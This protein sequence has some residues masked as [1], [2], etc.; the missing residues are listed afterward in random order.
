[1]SNV[2]EAT[3]CHT[4]EIDWLIDWLTDSGLFNAAFQ[5]DILC[6]AIAGNI[7]EQFKVIYRFKSVEVVSVSKHYI[8]NSYKETGEDPR[9]FNFGTVVS[10]MLRIL[11][12]NEE[13]SDTHCTGGCIRPTGYVV[14]MVKGNTVPLPD[15]EPHS[16]YIVLI[17]LFEYYDVCYNLQFAIRIRVDYILCETWEILFQ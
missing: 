11:Y 6:S 15:I 1:V 17:D 10:L 13:D 4:Y 12:P 8:T 9:T 7:I 5:L 14:M 3:V 2:S 16:R